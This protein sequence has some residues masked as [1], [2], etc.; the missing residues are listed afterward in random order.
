MSGKQKSGLNHYL[1]KRIIQ[2]N[3]LYIFNNNKE[4]WLSGTHLKEMKS[5]CNS[6]VKSNVLHEVSDEELNNVMEL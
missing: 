5:I 4:R 2:K 3:R 1:P 6:F